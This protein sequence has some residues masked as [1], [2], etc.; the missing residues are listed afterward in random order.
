M[1][2]TTHGMQ[3]G[4]PGGTPPSPPLTV[5]GAGSGPSPPL[6]TDPW[7][8]WDGLPLQIPPAPIYDDTGIAPASF[9][10]LVPLSVKGPQMAVQH[11]TALNTPL[12]RHDEGLML[13]DSGFEPVSQVIRQLSQYP[14]PPICPVSH[15]EAQP[16]VPGVASPSAGD[17]PPLESVV[18]S[19]VSHSVGQDRGDQAGSQ[20]PDYPSSRGAPAIGSLLRVRHSAAV[21]RTL[22]LSFSLTPPA[23]QLWLP[24]VSAKPHALTPLSP[25]LHIKTVCEGAPPA[26]SEG[27]P[28]IKTPHLY[29]AE[30]QALSSQGIPANVTEPLGLR[31]LT[32]SNKAEAEGEPEMTSAHVFDKVRNVVE[33][34]APATPAAMSPE[35]RDMFNTNTYAAMRPGQYTSL[36]RKNTRGP[37][38]PGSNPIGAG[39]NTRQ[40]L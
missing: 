32:P 26:L 6:D 33:N 12:L 4:P 39:G 5:Q 1:T 13:G 22:P 2:G 25:S 23:D 29:A 10:S 17:T 24:Q 16:Q 15:T 20:C 31:R 37:R 34:L 35:G 9:Q 21:R 18:N 11:W 36:R 40:E 38:T 7:A 14:P 19:H 8:A 27:H 30:I 3:Y 28:Y